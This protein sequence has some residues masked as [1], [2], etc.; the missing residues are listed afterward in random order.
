[1]IRLAGMLRRVTPILN[2]FMSRMQTCGLYRHYI[3]VALYSLGEVSKRGILLI[4]AC[5]DRNRATVR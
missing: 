2:A 3:Y 1:M 4:P 5:I